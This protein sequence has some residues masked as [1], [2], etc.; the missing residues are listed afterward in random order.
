M[1]FYTSGTIPFN[2]LNDNIRAP[3]VSETQNGYPC[4]DADRALFN[5]TTSYAWGQVHNAIEAAGL[6]VDV[7]DLTQLSSV[8]GA[9]WESISAVITAAGLTPD[10]WDAAQLAEA[11]RRSGLQHRTDVYGTPG[12]HTFTPS[13]AGWFWVEVYGGGGGAANSIG[14]GE[15]GGGGGYAGKWV[16]LNANAVVNVTVG[17][18]GSSN[19]SGSANGTSGGSSSFGGH[20]SASGGGGATFSGS[21]GAGG[22]GIGGDINLYGQSGTDG[23]S[24]SYPRFG[25]GGDAAGPMGGKAGQS[26]GGGSTW[27]GG[28]GSFGDVWA[29]QPS[30]GAVIIRY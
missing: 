20:C 1:P 5:F 9:S 21:P 16:F 30:P 11:I 15:G 10:R 13:Q 28:G 17:A 12:N 6:T 4:G 27:P 2:S 18:A 23:N 24:S 3:T 29:A 26:G 22:T 8:I 7:T 25:R 19:G 14:S